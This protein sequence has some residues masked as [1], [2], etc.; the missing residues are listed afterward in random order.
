MPFFQ[1]NAV[2]WHCK[3]IGESGA[4][5]STVNWEFRVVPVCGAPLSELGGAEAAV[6]SCGAVEC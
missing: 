4:M 2:R 5:K 6:R 3:R 1:C